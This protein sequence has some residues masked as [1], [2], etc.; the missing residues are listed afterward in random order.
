MTGLLLP[1]PCTIFSV[2]ITDKVF[3]VFCLTL[4]CFLFSF[5]LIKILLLCCQSKHSIIDLHLKLHINAPQTWPQYKSTLQSHNLQKATAFIRVECVVS[6]SLYCPE[7][8]WSCSNGGKGKARGQRKWTSCLLFT[9]TFQGK[10]SK[11]TN[12][13]GTVPI[14]ASDEAK[15]LC[16]CSGKTGSV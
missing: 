2:K 1:P 9:Q 13:Q 3:L 4:F 16:D 11:D 5:L 7:H 8:R 14:T 10:V 6:S 15:K 12:F